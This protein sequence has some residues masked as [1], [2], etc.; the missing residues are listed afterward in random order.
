MS[1][2]RYHF[3]LVFILVVIKLVKD[4]KIEEK[5]SFL[6]G[7]LIELEKIAKYDV[8][9]AN[10]KALEI[11]KSIE[12]DRLAAPYPLRGFKAKWQIIKDYI[13]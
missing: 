9:V 7:D 6:L 13:L 11:Y 12:N 10:Q 4:T 2:K 5:A 8:A 3:A 1:Y